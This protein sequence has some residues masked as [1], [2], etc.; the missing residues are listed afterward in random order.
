MFITMKKT[1]KGSPNGLVVETYNEGQVYDL[2]DKLAETFIEMGVAKK[3][4]KPAENKMVE[5]E[6]NKKEDKKEDKKE[7]IEED[8][9]EDVKNKGKKK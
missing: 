6:S 9:K 7:V 8:I 2:P 4:S 1:E 5:P 3:G